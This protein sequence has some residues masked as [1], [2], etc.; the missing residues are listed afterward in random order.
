MKLQTLFISLSLCLCIGG[1]K[2][3]AQATYY[4][5]SRTELKAFAAW[6]EQNGLQKAAEIESIEPT[7]SAQAAA[8]PSSA[9]PE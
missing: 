2:L 7:E 5:S 9:I 1:G 6:R 4:I 8:T 3:Y